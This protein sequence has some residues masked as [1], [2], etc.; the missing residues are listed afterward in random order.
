MSALSLQVAPSP[1]IA[2]SSKCA[3]CILT[4]PPCHDPSS[5]YMSLLAFFLCPD[6]TLPPSLQSLAHKCP[7]LS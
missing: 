1:I 5:E 7:S 3:P 6:K 4:F 2:F